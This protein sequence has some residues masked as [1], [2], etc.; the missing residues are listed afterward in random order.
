[1]Y[2]LERLAVKHA[3][4]AKELHPMRLIHAKLPK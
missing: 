3:L 2:L 1:M 4:P